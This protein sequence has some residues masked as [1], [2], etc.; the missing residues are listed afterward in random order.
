MQEVVRYLVRCGLWMSTYVIGCCQVVRL[1]FGTA[2][3]LVLILWNSHFDLVQ[4]EIADVVHE[5][6]Y[7]L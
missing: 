7:M 4:V 6:L 2:L 5:T 3:W 1:L